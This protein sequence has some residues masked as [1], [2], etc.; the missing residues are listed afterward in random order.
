MKHLSF[1]TAFALFG[2][3]VSAQAQGR[4]PVASLPAATKTPKVGKVGQTLAVSIGSKKSQDFNFDLPKGQ[5]YVYVDAQGLKEG[6]SVS[7]IDATLILLK[8]N[9][10][11]FPQFGSNLIYWNSH[12]R[13]SRAGQQFSFAKPTGVRFRIK[14]DAEGA[15]NFWLT[16]VPLQPMK[17]LLFSFG[18]KVM[19]AKIGP[20][21]GT[22]GPLNHREFDY[23]RATIPAGKWSI[24]LGAHSEAGK[25]FVSMVSLNARGVD[26]MGSISIVGVENDDRKE[27]IVT[28]AKPTTLLFRVVNEGAG[29][30]NP[31]TYDITIE[32]SDG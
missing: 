4:T 19:T 29:D 31:V 21:N 32:P 5:F 2:G 30:E 13:T 1:L 27:E 20:N 7:K 14:N 9:G 25:C 23:L 26:Y 24:S 22:G 28:L 18:S 11:Q 3:L 15:N 17:F 12:E 10:A 6:D 8:R 16:V